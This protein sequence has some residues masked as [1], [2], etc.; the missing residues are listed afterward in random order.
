MPNKLKFGKKVIEALPVGQSTDTYWDD[1]VTGLGLRIQPT[2]TKTFFFQGRTKGKLVKITIGKFGV[3]TTEEAKKLAKQHASDLTK[4][5]DPRN[6]Q[7]SEEKLATFGDMMSA[8]IDLLY[9]NNKYDA[10][11][12]ESAINKNIKLAFPKIWKKTASEVNL[13][14]CIK[15][16]GKLKDEDKPRQA[17]KVR[18]YIRTAFSEAINARGNVNAP[19][20]LRAIKVTYNP[21]RDIRKVEGSS[22]TDDRVLEKPEFV[23][24]WKRLKELPE[25]ARSLAMLHVLTGGQR[26]AQ[27]ARLTLDDV[28]LSSKT[29]T[30]YDPKGRRKTARR[31]VIPLLD[32]SIEYIKKLTEGGKYLFSCNGGVSPIHVGYLGAVVKQVNMQMENAGELAKGKFTPGCIRATIETRL[33]DRPYRVS[34]DVLAQLLSHGLGGVQ[35]RHYQ[36]YDFFEDKLEALEKLYR[37]LEELPEPKAQ[38]IEFGAVG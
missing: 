8:Y 9:S 32:D 5:L 24:Y 36:R 31:H 33:A 16:V 29:L 25:P 34:S 22:N 14:D 18:S 28:D 38:V 21:A 37:L 13:D 27:L 12:V 3:L 4:G 20:S 23:A 2:G 1:S 35:N 11:A 6:K 19:K 15:L 30:L 10:K 17:D 26:Q 7:N